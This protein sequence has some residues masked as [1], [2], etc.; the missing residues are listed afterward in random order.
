MNTLVL[1]R[2]G[3][4]ED[5]KPGEPDQERGLTDKGIKKT[6]QAAAGLAA[7]IDKPDVILTSPK[8]RAVQSAEIVGRAF[9]R[10]PEVLDALGEGT[11]KQILA[12]LQRRSESVVLIV[13]H[14]PTLSQ[15][16]G[17]ICT[18]RGR[19]YIELRKAGCA[20]IEMGKSGGHGQPRAAI[21]WLATA[22][23]L[24]RY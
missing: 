22:G 21:K 1:F 4:A 9:K 19:S 23:M 15:L 12:D 13:G 14:E 6:Q 16:V 5:P 3:I 18:G 17:L 24:R 20:C 7:L 10:E 8:L 2:H 11:A